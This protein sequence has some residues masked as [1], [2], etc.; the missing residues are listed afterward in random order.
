MKLYFLSIFMLLTGCYGWQTAD[1]RQQTADSRQQTADSRQQ[2][3][4][5][6]QQTADSAL[7]T[8]L[9]QY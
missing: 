8:G 1:S 2:T 5:S 3:A 6:R 7:C 4:D 9:L